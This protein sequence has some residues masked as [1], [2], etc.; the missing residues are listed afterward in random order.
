MVG[1]RET[2][3]RFNFEVMKFNNFHYE[4]VGEEDEVFLLNYI[5]LSVYLNL[6]HIITPFRPTIAQVL[7]KS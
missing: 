2:R 1:W 6:P 4:Y 7:T 3:N 5:N